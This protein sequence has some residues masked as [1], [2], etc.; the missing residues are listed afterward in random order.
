MARTS[1]DGA[2][3]VSCFVVE[4]GTPGLSF[5]ANERK[6]GWNAQPTAQVIFDDCRI[7]AAHQVGEEGEGFKFA[8]SGLDGGR[9][10][11]GACSLGGAQKA[12]EA[13][14]QYTKDRT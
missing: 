10:N 3:G 6:M 2:R 8:M 7:P 9:I 13:S 11:I 12:I 1:D 4:N 5:G 14:I